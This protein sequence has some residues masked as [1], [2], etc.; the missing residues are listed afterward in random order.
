VINTYHTTMMLNLMGATT[1]VH[2]DVL[3]ALSRESTAA[4][5]WHRWHAYPEGTWADVATALGIAKPVDAQ[6]MAAGFAT[7]HGLSLQRTPGTG[8][9]AFEAEV[10]GLGEGDA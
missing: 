8:L 3:H 6:I 4:R 7:E 10:A 2:R 5:A 1:G 9:A